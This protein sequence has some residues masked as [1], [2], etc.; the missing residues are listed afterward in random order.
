MRRTW[1]PFA[2]VVAVVAVTTTAV[3]VTTWEPDGGADPSTLLVARVVDEQ[4]RPIADTTLRL[5]A[6]ADVSTDAE[7]DLRAPLSGGA[8]LVTLAA[9]GYLPRTQAVQPGEPAEFRLTSR[10]EET[11]SLRFGGDVMFGRRYYDADDD[12]DRSDGLLPEDAS[13]EEHAALL[14]HVRPLLEDADLTVVN[15]ESA[16]SEEPWVDPTRT[17]PDA[18]HPTKEFVFAS[19]PESVQA[20]VEVGVDVV[21]LGNN[22]LYDALEGGLETTLDT[23]DEAG[24]PRFGGGR[25]VDEAWAPAFVKRKGQVVAFLGCTTITGREHPISYVADEEHG[26]AARCTEQRLRDEVLAAAGRADLVTVMIHGGEEYNRRQT[27]LVQRLSDIAADAGAGLV[28]NGHPHVVGEVALQDDRLVAQ[29]LGNL[30][31]DQT[32]WPTFLSYLLRIDVR[33]GAPV[34]STVDPLFLDGYLPRPTVGLLADAAA[35]KAGGPDADPRLGLRPPGAVMTPGEESPFGQGQVPLERG[36]V[37]RLGPGWWL[38]EPDRETERVQVGEDLLW[39]GSFEDMDT[40]PA[41]SGAHGWALGSNG[42]LSA[43]AACSGSV[44]LELRRSPL[45]TTDVVATPEHRQLVTAGSR[46]SLVADVRDASPGSTLEL[47]WYP[48]TKGGSASATTLPIPPVSSD[49]DACEQVRLD[50]TVPDGIVAVQPF[51][52]LAPP[53][54]VHLGPTLAID[55]VQLVVWSQGE[56]GRRYDVVDAREDISVDLTDD[57]ALPADALPFARPR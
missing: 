17:R 39:T 4:G 2:A 16:L 45:S 56:Y 55:N 49:E 53:D 30:L 26:G 32:V 19:E 5:G 29:T 20:L 15:L 40:D 41:T 8:Q 7:G 44:G 23:L 13:V 35:R 43:A 6:D 9:E 12:G 3:V 46:L 57:S 33:A 11:V 52:R 48:D 14:E 10:A 24:V 37:T 28:V 51:L 18:F 50:A 27:E 22:H 54:D 31:F 42:R 21:A 1:L 34:L 38:P 25:T 36:T 47:R